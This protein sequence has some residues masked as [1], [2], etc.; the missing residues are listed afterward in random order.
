MLVAIV[1]RMGSGK[2][3][4]MS[5]LLTFLRLKISSEYIYVNY[6]LSGSTKI[7]NAREL[8]KIKNGIVGLDEFWASMDSRLWKDNVFLTRWVLQTRKKNLLVFYT[9]QNF[10]QIDIRVRQAT[11]L[12]IFCEKITSSTST[13]FKFIF[14]NPLNSRMLK[15][16]KVLESEMKKLYYLYDTFEAI[17][18]IK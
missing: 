2:T 4:L 8:L 17:K 16:F 5:V 9:T 6:S 11:D 1:G 7:S 14:L 3:L 18:L 13:F 15:S 10:R 12:L